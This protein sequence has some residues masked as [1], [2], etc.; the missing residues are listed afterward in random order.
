MLLSLS[1]PSSVDDGSS[2][3][4]ACRDGTTSLNFVSE[5]GNIGVEE[6]ECR[7]LIELRVDRM[8]IRPK[9]GGDVV[10]SVV[11]M[12]DCDGGGKGRVREAHKR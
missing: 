7:N 11:Y 12:V 2:P 1:L 4:F 8:P 3:N 9:C 6:E 5:G 10:R